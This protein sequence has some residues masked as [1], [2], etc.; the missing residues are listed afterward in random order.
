[1][2]DVAR[3]A[4]HVDLEVTV[5]ACEGSLRISVGDS[6]ETPSMLEWERAAAVAEVASYLQ[7]FVCEKL[8][9]TWPTCSSHDLGLHATTLDGVAV[10]LCSQGPHTVTMVGGLEARG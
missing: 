2:S 9:G 4:P 1:M 7:E 6:F 8:R 5:D 3:S 10:W